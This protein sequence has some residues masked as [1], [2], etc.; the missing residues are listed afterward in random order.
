[1]FY[2]MRNWVNK[3]TF[4]NL[5]VVFLENILSRG[6]SF[7]LIIIIAR[8]LGP[9]SY[10]IYSFVTISIIFLSMFLDC[11]MENVALCFSGK[12]QTKREEIF[13]VY[14]LFKTAMLAILSII[15]LLCPSLITHLLNKSETE[16]Y[17][18]IILIG[19]VG[20]SYLY[21]ITTYLQ[22][23]E[24]FVFRACINIGLYV[25][26]F[27]CILILLK[28]SVSDVKT[29]SIYFAMAS[30][31]FVLYFTKQFVIFLKRFV[32]YRISKNLLKDMFHYAKWMIAGAAAMNIMTRLDFYVVTSLLSFHDAG[33]YNSAFQLFLPLSLIPFAFG[34]VFMAKLSK[35]T[36][37]DAI[38]KYLRKVVVAGS[39]ISVLTILMLPFCRDLILFVFGDR[40]LEA[41]NI[42]K[43]L[44]FSF[45]FTLWN[46]MFG[47]VFYSLGHSK[48]MAIG[49]FIQL[50]IFSVFAFVFVPKYGMVG[51]ALSRVISDAAYLGVVI[52][53]LTRIIHT[54]RTGL[55]KQYN[56]D[57]EK[58][59]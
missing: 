52:I 58:M 49:A 18:N 51:A 37:F 23:L 29:L 50:L 57:F 13:S 38:K 12:Y 55:L 28:L 35:Y 27:M 47:I 2:L 33:I 5:S 4:F 56:C 8:T 53:L 42:F 59:V 36:Q 41:V 10:G 48:F 20:E 26:R 34:K 6:L 17:F 3:R 39:V 22:S 45:I 24:K 14:F 9:E 21:I 19:C 31:P 7:V 54:G 32:V 40:Y 25:V 43:I 30:I 44:L 15:F 11:S 16:K 46:V 1:M